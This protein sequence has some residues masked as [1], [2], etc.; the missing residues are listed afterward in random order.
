MSLKVGTYEFHQIKLKN[1]R[2]TLKPIALQ[3]VDYRGL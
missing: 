2:T 1:H 3:M